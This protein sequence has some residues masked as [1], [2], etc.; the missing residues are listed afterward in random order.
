MLEKWSRTLF[1]V[2]MLILSGIVLLLGVWKEAFL[3]LLVPVLAMT[4]IGFY[5]IF[6]TQHTNLRNFPLLGHFRFLLESVR[7]EIYQYFIEKEDEEHPFSREKRSVVYQRSK[8]VLDTIPFG[9]KRFY[10]AIEFKS[11]PNQK[12]DTFHNLGQVSPCF[13]LEDY[14]NDKKVQIPAGHTTDKIFECLGNTEPEIYF[15]YGNAKFRTERIF[16]LIARQFHAG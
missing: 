15:I 12:C 8:K 14:S 16:K 11:L 6:Q 10:F 9:T 3:W 5:D 1:V 2:S 13:T 4:A 7:P